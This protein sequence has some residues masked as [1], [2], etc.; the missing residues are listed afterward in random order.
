MM[1]HLLIASL[2]DLFPC[3]VGDTK[4]SSERPVAFGG[5][6][7]WRRAGEEDVEVA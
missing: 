3:N 4:G 5:V 6:I 1:V 2:A 7:E